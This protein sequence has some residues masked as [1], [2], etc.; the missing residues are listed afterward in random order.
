VTI[1]LVKVQFF[2]L[3]EVDSCL[4]SIDLY[5]TRGCSHLYPL[6]YPSPSPSTLYL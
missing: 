1:Y 4:G 3:T 2:F 5:G 6:F